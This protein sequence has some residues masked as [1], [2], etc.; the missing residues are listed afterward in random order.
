MLKQLSRLTV[1]RPEPPKFIVQVQFRQV[2]HVGWVNRE[3][4]TVSARDHLETVS[5]IL[6]RYVIEPGERLLVWAPGDGW[7]RVFQPGAGGFWEDTSH[8][9]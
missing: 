6:T 5:F 9:H 1:R 4:V 2:G 8:A 3:P 7:P